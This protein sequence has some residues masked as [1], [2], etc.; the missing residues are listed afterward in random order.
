MIYASH[1]EIP[2]PL[3]KAINIETVYSETFSETLNIPYITNNRDKRRL[4]S[5]RFEGLESIQLVS[6]KGHFSGFT[7]TSDTNDNPYNDII[8]RYYT[9]KSGYIDLHLKEADIN[10]L[11]EKGSLTFGSGIA[12]LDDGTSMPVSLGRITIR[13]KEHWEKYR[14][15]VGGGGNDY[16]YNVDFKTETPIKITSIDLSTFEPHQEAVDMELIVD[17]DKIYKY[18]ELTA[19]TKPISVDRS[20][21][22]VFTAKDHAVSSQWRFNMISMDMSYIKEGQ[23]YDAWIYCPYY[24]AGMDEESVEAYVALWRTENE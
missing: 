6:Q 22:V 14:L 11:E 2:K 23:S 7:F 10:R 24:G 16:H 18:A 20:F 21:Q 19:E 15:R 5:I 17:D 4:E 8:G 3:F 12:T 1:Q 9:L 13:T